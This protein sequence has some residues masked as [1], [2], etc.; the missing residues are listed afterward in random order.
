MQESNDQLAQD[1]LAESRS[2]EEQFLFSMRQA[3]FKA[4]IASAEV[5][6]RFSQLLLA[7]A[8]GAI[9]L[10]VGSLPDLTAAPWPA[11]LRA[12]SVLLGISM[13]FGTVQLLLAH[14]AA[15]VWSGFKAQEDGMQAGAKAALQLPLESLLM[16]MRQHLEETRR[17]HLPPERWLIA[18][19]LRANNPLVGL[20]RV[21]RKLRLMVQIQALLFRLQLVA[22]ASAAAPVVFALLSTW[23]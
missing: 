8:A 6:E 1:Q 20:E 23:S 19:C 2:P 13:L 15:L 5:N 11:V 18:S 10:I 9:A 14:L 22:A 16:L 3:A 17:T 7:F 4:D 12:T 21:Q